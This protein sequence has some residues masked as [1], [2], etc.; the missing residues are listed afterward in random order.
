MPDNSIGEEQEVTIERL[1]VEAL[2][3]KSLVD[4]ECYS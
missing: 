2:V 3:A 4:V 1:Q